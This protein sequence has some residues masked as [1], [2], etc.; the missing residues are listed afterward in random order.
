MATGASKENSQ[1][2]THADKGPIYLVGVSTR[3]KSRVGLSNKACRIG[4]AKAAV[5]PEPV[6]AN[7]IMSLPTVTTTQNVD[8][9][10]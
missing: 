4:R 2:S 10:L 5:L 3:A 6:S 9:P 7:P 8:R 1:G